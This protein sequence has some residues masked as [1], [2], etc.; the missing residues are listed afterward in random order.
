MPESRPAIRPD[1]SIRTHRD[2]RNQPMPARPAAAAASATISRRTT[3]AVYATKAAID[4]RQTYGIVRHP[5]RCLS[6]NRSPT[7]KTRGTGDV[8]C[9]SGV[10]RKDRR[11]ATDAE[12]DAGGSAAYGRRRDRAGPDGNA[13]PRVQHACVS[14]DP[15]RSSR[16]SRGP[17]AESSAIFAPLRALRSFP[18]RSQ[19]NQNVTKNPP[20]A[21][22]WW[23]ALS[24][25]SI[26]PVST[27]HRTSARNPAALTSP[28]R[29]ANRPCFTPPPT[30]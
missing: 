23:R 15:V 1:R 14:W 7:N 24:S 25:R 30:W 17:P 18:Y 26:P 19:A 9:V 28:C 21:A 10:H 11:G 20:T 22:R 2:S 6:W 29:R 13:R 5:T 3:R 27:Y 16:A 12:D 8:L 4:A